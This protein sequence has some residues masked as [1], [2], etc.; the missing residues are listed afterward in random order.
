MTPEKADHTL[1]VTGT[2]HTYLAGRNKSSMS[3]ALDDVIYGDAPPSSFVM[4]SARG[5]DSMIGIPT[6]SIPE[7][8]DPSLLMWTAMNKRLIEADYHIREDAAL[9]DVFSI[10][11]DITVACIFGAWK[12]VATDMEG[13]AETIKNVR[14]RIGEMN[15]VQSFKGGG[16]NSA[17]RG[18]LRTKQI[19]GKCALYL[20]RN[21]K[22]GSK[23]EISE[24]VNMSVD[25][26]RRMVNPKDPTDYYF[27]Q[28][29][30]KEADYKNPEAWKEVENDSDKSEVQSETQCVW[31]IPDGENSRYAKDNN[32]ELL[33]PNIK[34]ED[35]VNV[36]ENLVYIES[37]TKI[38]NDNIVTTIMNKRYLTRMSIIAVQI[39]I[40]GLIHII[41]GNERNPPAPAPDERIKTVNPT[42]YARQKKMFDD[43]VANMLSMI[44]EVY[45]G[46]IN[47]KPIGYVDSVKVI[48]DEPKMALTGE[49]MENVLLIYDSIIA[50]A[51][52]IPLTIIT[53]VGTEL[54]T[55]R[56]TKSVTDISLL[57]KQSG[58]HDALMHILKIEFANEIEE[59]GIDIELQPLDK[60]D[61]KTMAEIVEI[62]ARA[63]LAL[64]NAGAVD[65]TL[66][67]LVLAMDGIPLQKVDMSGDTRSFDDGIDPIVVEEVEE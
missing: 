40:V 4:A 56:L 28:T 10:L 8:N 23:G 17:D 60:A 51:V 35:W 36:L 61:A 38:L 34:N 24:V 33:Y 12:V 32:G 20:Y 59:E 7:V 11:S 47:G 50:K 13:S 62:A 64:R 45:E 18:A 29:F 25:G 67:N 39:G 52:G 3:A 19:H 53:S 48:R 21:N 22:A 58:V 66:Q 42:E 1:K 49:F 30:K 63:V 27:Y 2:Q 26:L 54:S 15:L 6:Q 37:P 57:D 65:E 9:D 31:Y 55:S 5:K 41:F 44:D 14:R 16:I 46:M 43:F